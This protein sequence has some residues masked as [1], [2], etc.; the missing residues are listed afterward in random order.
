V[1]RILA[2]LPLFASACTV[3]DAPDTLQQLAVFGFVH[4][5][6]SARQQTDT[7]EGLIPLTD[8]HAEQLTEGFRIA[9]LGTGDL[10][11]VGV[12]GAEGGNIKGSAATIHMTS[13]L[14]DV[15][16][17]WSH[18]HMDE[19]LD[20]TVEFEIE[21][22]DGDRDCFLAHECDAYSYD[23]HRVLDMSIFGTATQDF[24]RDFAWV[25]REDDAGPAVL[26]VRELAPLGSEMSTDIVAVHQGYSYSMFLDDDGTR[27]LDAIW[28]DAEAIG[29][30]LPDAFALDFAVSSMEK[31]AQQVDA[32]VDENPE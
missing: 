11:K 23:G 4:F 31:T 12:D 5:D 18:P 3:T 6:G 20:N 15:A 10:E 21:A 16:R 26:A 28:I 24:H 27:R 25:A 1:R 7:V 22:E 13:S 32:W 9:C 19:V 14:D 8:E 30:D 2:S 29:I 17:A